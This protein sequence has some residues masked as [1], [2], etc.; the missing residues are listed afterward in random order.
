M[1]QLR[2]SNVPLCGDGTWDVRCNSAEI[3][4]PSGVPALPHAT[5]ITKALCNSPLYTQCQ[6]LVYSARGQP[7]HHACTTQL[8][9]RQVAAQGRLYPAA[10]YTSMGCPQQQCSTGVHKVTSARGRLYLEQNPERLCSQLKGLQ[11]LT[12]GWRGRGG[13]RGR[14]APAAGVLWEVVHLL[15]R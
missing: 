10:S 4:S 13:R 7:H 5:T 8:S 14:R 11:R 12:R 6:R 2:Y 9:S 15:L 1:R 3:I